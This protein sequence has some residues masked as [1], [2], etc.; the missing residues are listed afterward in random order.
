MPARKVRP[1]VVPA[2]RTSRATKSEPGA[3]GGR[4]MK[5]WPSL[6]ARMSSKKMWHAPF[7]ARRL[8]TVSSLQSR[9]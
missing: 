8:P 3:S 1:G 6:A 2:S 9:P 7:L 5:I 4:M